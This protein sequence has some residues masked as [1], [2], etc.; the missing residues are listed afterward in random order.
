MAK[1]PDNWTFIQEERRLVSLIDPDI[2]ISQRDEFY[3]VEVS[4]LFSAPFL[5]YEEAF[6]YA[7]QLI[8]PA[9]TIR[10]KIATDSDRVNIQLSG[11][12]EGLA[13]PRV[14]PL[15]LDTQQRFLA[16]IGA[17]QTQSPVNRAWVKEHSMETR[18]KDV[19]DLIKAAI[20]RYA[21]T[22]GKPYGVTIPS[23][24]DTLIETGMPAEVAAILVK[25]AKG[26]IYLNDDV[27]NLGSS[28][29]GRSLISRVRHLTRSALSLVREG[30][31]DRHYAIKSDSYGTIVNLEYQGRRGWLPLKLTSDKGLSTSEEIELMVD[32]AESKIK[33][34]RIRYNNT[35]IIVDTGDFEEWVKSRP[36]PTDPNTIKVV[37]QMRKLINIKID[38]VGK[39]YK[40]LNVLVEKFRPQDE[41]P[42]YLV[43]SINEAL[44]AQGLKLIQFTALPDIKSKDMP[45]KDWGAIDILEWIFLRIEE[46]LTFIA[47]DDTERKAPVRITFLRYRTANPPQSITNYLEIDLME[48]GPHL[49]H[50]VVPSFSASSVNVDYRS[51]KGI[52]LK[53]LPDVLATITLRKKRKGRRLPPL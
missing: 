52:P 42:S 1:V 8:S 27:K 29:E 49:Q 41:A 32:A 46:R 48:S 22:H 16:P 23:T 26:Y 24:P 37:H 38:T 12:R 2:S 5:D 18:F 15:T 4:N 19:S 28:A 47:D 43:T 34:D 35:C 3:V 6:K 17:T 30:M 14:Y 39:F 9:R 50:S 33:E 45:N 44:W 13:G 53:D 36:D 51:F 31:I 11:G 25:R 7:S 21:K 20:I 40:G 10:R